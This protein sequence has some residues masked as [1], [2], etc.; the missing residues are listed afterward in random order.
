MIR[1]ALALAVT[2]MSSAEQAVSG[3]ALTV[4]VYNYARLDSR[5]L[6][7]AQR[8]TSAILARAHV[9][10][11]WLACATSPSEMHGDSPCMK[12]PRGADVVLKLLPPSMAKKTGQTADTF[13]F[14][15]PTTP[16]GLGAASV[17]VRRAEELAMSA[18]MSVPYDA[19]K[20]VVLGHVIAHEIGHLLLGPGKHSA[21]GIMESPWSRA[22]LKRMAT[23]H[24]S[25]T[26]AEVQLIRERLTLTSY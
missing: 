1:F 26:S 3:P 12:P 17:F 8:E 24:L 19:A 21:S 10:V 25:F 15:V 13:G 18:P 4:R 14:A 22:V 7:A 11:K 6:A 5:S 23:S 20:A 9:D 2:S 16:V